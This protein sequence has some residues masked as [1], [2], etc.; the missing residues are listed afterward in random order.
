MVGTIAEA[1]KPVA[2]WTEETMLGRS[3]STDSSSEKGGEEAPPPEAPV[4]APANPLLDPLVF[5]LL[6][7]PVGNQAALDVPKAL[8]NPSPKKQTEPFL[9]ETKHVDKNPRNFR[10]TDNKKNY[11]RRKI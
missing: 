11:G 6:N 3:D 4:A 5:L 1:M 2:K 9:S 7:N 10:A 8:E